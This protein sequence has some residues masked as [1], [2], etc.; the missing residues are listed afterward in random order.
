MIIIEYDANCDILLCS[1]NAGD[2]CT[3]VYSF[4]LCK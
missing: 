3:V 4:K 2:M 1:Y